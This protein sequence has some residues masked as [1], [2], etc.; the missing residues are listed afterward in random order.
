MTEFCSI[1]NNFLEVT[2][3]QKVMVHV[4]VSESITGWSWIIKV[5][6]WL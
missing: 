6:T 1:S 5:S 2:N 3:Y 4:G